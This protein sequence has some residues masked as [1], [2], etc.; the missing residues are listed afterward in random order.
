MDLYSF[1]GG[2]PVNRFDPTG[3]FGKDPLGAT[4]RFFQGF[5]AGMTDPSD[6]SGASG[7]GGFIS[8][9]GA[10]R[11]GYNLGNNLVSR[12]LITASSFLVGGEGAAATEEVEATMA[13]EGLELGEESTLASEAE[14]A[15]QESEAAVPTGCE[16]RTSDG[17]RG[18]HIGV[19]RGG[20]RSER[21]KCKFKRCSSWIGFIGQLWHFA[22]FP[23]LQGRGE[24]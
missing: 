12:L 14:T 1:C 19:C 20:R 5:A 6:S 11:L 18:C 15:A 21:R 2:D 10:A 23:C 7:Y 8:Q 24:L 9:T 13:G 4:G 17:E 22:K 3:R 16:C